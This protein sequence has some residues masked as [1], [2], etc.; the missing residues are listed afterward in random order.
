MKQPS[1]HP[2]MP[3]VKATAIGLGLSCGAV[4]SAVLES[5]QVTEPS[6]GPGDVAPK[7]EKP[8]PPVQVTDSPLEYRQFEKVEITGSSIVRK[9]QTQALPV[10]VITRSDI[11]NSGVKGVPELIQNLP[12]MFGFSEPGQLGLAR[13]GFSSSAIHGMAART[14]VLINGKRQAIYGRQNISGEDRSIVDLDMLPLGAVERV[15]I[16][17]DGASSLYGSDAIAGVV[18]IITRTERKGI[19]VS[20]NVRLPDGMKGQSK[21]ME[22]SWGQGTLNRDGYSWFASLGVENQAQLMGADRPYASE[23]RQYFRHQGRTYFVDG[24][25]LTAFQSGSPTLGAGLGSTYGG[26][27][28]NAQYQ[29]GRCPDRQVP[30]VGQP[31]CLYNPYPEFGLYP[32]TD[33]KR[34]YSKGSYYVDASRVVYAE[35]AYSEKSQYKNYSLWPTTYGVIGSSISSPGYALATANGFVP[36]RTYLMYRPTELGTMARRYDDSNQR[37]VVGIKGEI[38]EWNYNASL[39]QTESESSYGFDYALYSNAGTLTTDSR[40]SSLYSSNPATQNLYNFFISKK[41]YQKVENGRAKIQALDFSASKTLFEIDGDPVLLGAGFEWRR[42][43]DRFEGSYVGPISQPDFDAQ[44]HVFAQYIEVQ[45]PVAPK[46]EVIT[47]LRNDHYS[48]FG[49]TTHGKVSTK[50]LVNDAWMLRGSWGTGFRAPTVA[51]IQKTEMFSPTFLSV[52]CNAQLT[53]LAAQLSPQG[54]CVNDGRFPIY[55]TGSDALKP[56]LSTQFNWGFQFKASAQHVWSM[57]YWRVNMKNTLRQYPGALVL[58]DP[59]KY[60]QYYTLVDNKL[61]LNLPSVNLGSSSKSGIDFSWA[62]RQPTEWGRFHTQVQGTRF[63]KSAQ[64]IT[65]EAGQTSDLGEYSADSASVTPVMRTQWTLG[66]LGGDWGSQVTVNHVTGYKDADINAR[67]ALTLE[68]VTV[69]GRRVPAFW[70]LD[71]NTTYQLAPKMVMEAKVMNLLNKQA[72]L[73]FVQTTS[74]LNS[75]NTTYS[76][77]WGRVVQLSLH[78]KF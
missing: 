36:G 28:W 33:S 4:C 70:T 34:F 32:Q 66:L 18:N 49:N 19:E 3:W 62:Y 5:A 47:A 37:V 12:V 31:A 40:F 11:K 1:I 67:D 44:R 23:G 17:T 63:L 26:R 2:V 58:S 68:Q 50:W 72:P 20:T 42:Q 77:F 53:Q 56:E 52:S 6:A 48:D 15:E 13:A 25:S 46:F 29:D 35:L 78:M 7:S 41:S 74:V 38:N 14:L 27:L 55:T 73:S 71:W 64:M 22:L 10:Q 21:A 39:Y 61:G 16:L 59:F 51:Q 30:A 9:E 43:H 54:A 57:D 8:Y 65:P 76:N 69:K 45:W 60:S 75:F 24:S